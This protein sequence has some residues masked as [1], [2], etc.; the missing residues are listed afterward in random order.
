MSDPNKFCPL[1][2]YKIIISVTVYDYIVRD[3]A[4]FVSTKKFESFFSKH[5]KDLTVE[6]IE[7]GATAIIQ[8][9][10]EV[11]TKDPFLLLNHFTYS[12]V[13]DMKKKWIVFLKR[14]LTTEIQKKVIIVNLH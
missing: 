7:N 8:F 4:I 11:K 2:L 12:I 10:G 13:Q 9:L 1:W 14:I 3:I 6:E 5:Y